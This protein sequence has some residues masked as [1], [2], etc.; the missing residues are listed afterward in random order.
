[1]KSLLRLS[2]LASSL[3][4]PLAFIFLVFAFAPG[5][6][7][8]A[9]PKSDKVMEDARREAVGRKLR[10]GCIGSNSNKFALGV[11][12]ESVDIFC[13]CQVRVALEHF[14]VEELLGYFVVSREERARDLKFQTALKP[15]H[16]ACVEET[17]RKMRELR[18]K[19]SEELEAQRKAQNKKAAD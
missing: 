2:S 19:Q 7:Q 18:Q 4:G 1:M 17:N 10:E 11:P 5:A 14:T 3:R 15:M 6:A 13:D 9:T 12:K 8:E 16:Q